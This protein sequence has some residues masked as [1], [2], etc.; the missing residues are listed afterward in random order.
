MS[1]ANILEYYF[2][3]F[4]CLNKND[5]ELIVCY[6]HAT[7]EFQSESTLYSFPE[8]QG[9]QGCS[10]NLK[11]VPQNFREVFN[12]DY[13]ITNDIIQRNQHCKVITDVKLASWLKKEL[14]F[15]SFPWQE[16]LH[17]KISGE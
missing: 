11:E 14:D 13:V 6:H 1:L 10:Q 5:Y 15:F 2:T 8:C 4:Y 16:H 9:T 17:S 7:Y 12:V 3:L